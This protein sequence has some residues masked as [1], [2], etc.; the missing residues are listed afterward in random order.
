MYLTSWA[1]QIA[2]SWRLVESTLS[3]FS[4]C[5]NHFNLHPSHLFPPHVFSELIKRVTQVSRGR[6]PVAFCKS[7]LRL[8][9]GFFITLC[10]FHPPQMWSKLREGFRAARET[11]TERFLTRGDLWGEI[12]GLRNSD[13]ANDA[14]V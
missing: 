4:G 6:L 13:L 11:G 1:L 3:P 5:S 12:T 10:S 8:P 14:E 2:G 7:P 9:E